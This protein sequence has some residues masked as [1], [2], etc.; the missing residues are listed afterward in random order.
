V[1]DAVGDQVVEAAGEG[2]DTIESSIDYVLGD[3][4]E[5]LTL[6]G[7]ANLNATGNALGNVLIGNDGDNR[8]EGGE[9]ADSLYGGLGDDYYVAESSD[10]SVQEYAGE[11]LDTVER[12]FETSLVLDSNVEN[13]VLADGVKTGNGNELDNAITGNAG[14]NTL[15]GWDG[16][17]ELLGLDGNDALFGGTGDDLLLG[18]VGNDYLDGGTGVDDLEGGTGDDT[19]IIDDS[20]DVVVEAADEGTDAVQT[21]ASYTLSANIENMFLMGDGAIDGTGNDLDNYIAGNDGVNTIHGGGG[22]DTIVSG[23]GNDVLIGDGGDDK[24]VF[25]ADSGSDVIDNTGGGFDGVFFTDGITRDRLSF[26]R[27]GDDLLIFVDNAT[28]PSVRVQGHFLGGDAA[29][30]YVQP[31]GGNY[32]TTA[33]INQ[34]VAGGETGGEYDQVIEG[35]AAG[36]QL[37]GGAGKDNVK[38]LGGDDT[39]FGMAGDDLLEGG[40]GSDYL[41]GGNGSGT[42]S[43]ADSLDGGAGDDTLNGEDGANALTGGEGDDSYVY[44]GGQDTIDNTGGGT[45]WLFFNDID[46]SRLGFHQDGDDLVITVDDDLNHQVRVL[47]HFLGGGMEISYVQPGSGNAISASQIDS[48]LTPMPD[49]DTGSGDGGGDTPPPDDTDPSDFDNVVDG[50]AAGEQ[51]L[52][53]SGKDLIHGL[54]GDD[55]LFGFEGDDRLEGGDGNDYLS[56]GNGSFAGSGDDTLTGGAGADTLVGE[57]GNDALEAGAGDDQYVW[58]AGSDFDLIDNTGGGTDWLFFNGVDRTRLGFHRDGDDLVIMVDG[59]AGQGVRIQDHFL[60][61]DLAISYIQPSDGYA[62]PASQIDSLL[63]PMPDSSQASPMAMRPK[64]PMAGVIDSSPELTPSTVS[65]TPASEPLWWR[66]KDTG[67]STWRAEIFDSSRLGLHRS[68]VNGTAQTP[69]GLHQ[70]VAAMASFSPSY[71]AALDAHGFDDPMG[72]SS[73]AMLSNV[74]RPHPMDSRI[75]QV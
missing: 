66:E 19:Y 50:T 17:D 32:L 22:S 59:D 18:G 14:D 34:L 56:G 57:D 30:D 2:D 35:T 9:G 37:V 58:Q 3:N 44:G 51:L 48:L 68:G 73:M 20:N 13:L 72:M 38:G 27:D 11:G 41:A 6:L 60:G 42:G 74:R 62:I 53:T 10:D 16:D 36:E 23:G 46:P 12:R 33:E 75:H 21:T 54:A 52:G 24:Y 31:D 1:I 61:G 45:D 39:L 7:T 28:D 47:D 70:L 63:T 4:F 26:T 5:N 65:A 43:G 55:T 49:G 25:D 40:D 15:G 64:E 67:W 71:G 29:I 69:A 8:L